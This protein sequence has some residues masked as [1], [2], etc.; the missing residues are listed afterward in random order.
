M[1]WGG[2][3]DPGGL[4]S[5]LIDSAY[6]HGTVFFAATGNNGRDDAV[7]FPANHP[8]VVAVGST[9]VNDVRVCQS[10]YGQYL[11][12]VAPSTSKHCASPEPYIWTTDNYSS[13]YSYNPGYP[14]CGVGCYAIPS[15]NDRYFG[16]FD[17]TSAACPLAAGIAVLLKSHMPGLDSSGLRA[18]LQGT[19]IDL[20]LPGRDNEYGYGRVDAYRALTEWG[21]IEENVTWSPSDTHDG[22][23]YVSGDLTVAPGATLTILPGAIIRV[24]STDD[25]AGGADT[26]RIEFNVEGELVASGTEANPIVFESWHPQTTQDW[27]GFYFD[28]QSDGGTFDHCVISRAE[29]AIESYVPLTVTDTAIDSCHYAG[30]VSQAGGAIIENC[31]L[32][33]PGFY[34]IFL[35]TDTTVVRNTTVDNA[36]GTALHIQSNAAATVRTSS[37]LN[38]DKGL[39]HSGST[40]FVDIDSSCTFSGNAIGVHFYQTAWGSNLKRSTIN[41]NT[42]AGVLCDASHPVIRWNVLRYNNTAISCTNVASPLIQENS[43]RN[44]TIGIMAGLDA[45]PNIGVYPT[46]GGNTIAYSSGYHVKNYHVGYLVK[47]ENNCWNMQ[48]EDSTNC[49]PKAGKIY[50]SVDTDHATCCEVSLSSLAE[51]APPPE[52]ERTVRTGLT[53]IVPNP[54]NP[55]TTIHYSLASPAIV[56]ICVYDV[57]GRLARELV[58]GM[59]VA[60]DHAEVWDG[61]NRRG[62]PVASGIYFVKM[63][64]GHQRFTMKTILLK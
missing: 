23:R 30:V 24:A 1:S 16:R 4:S 41:S 33:D 34:G 6:V 20:G 21:T 47:A 52:P 56:K 2:F 5:A 19:A 61:M 59:K 37:L 9:D 45:E 44:S 58:H 54:F 3:G 10:N 50:G 36:V 27:V 29:Y 7:Y 13:A 12:I 15:E 18:R 38:S 60:G 8:N 48:E 53:A 25:F 63:E 40:R 49:M 46:T 11:D 32:V 17:G 55:Q 51:I 35:A 64:V 22:V 39:Y 43:I 42:S 28:S 57:A 14:G 62:A 31:T 26:T